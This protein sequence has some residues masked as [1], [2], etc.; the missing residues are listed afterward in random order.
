[1]MKDYYDYKNDLLLK[2]AQEYI[3]DRHRVMIP[4]KDIILVTYKYQSGLYSNEMIV[5]YKIQSD[6][7]RREQAGMITKPTEEQ[8]TAYTRDKKLK[9]LGI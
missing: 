3:A 4:T 7:R 8:I 5:S 9:E 6:R 2:M 1:M